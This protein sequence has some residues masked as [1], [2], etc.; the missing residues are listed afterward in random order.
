ME[1]SERIV[2]EKKLNDGISFKEIGRETS[3][4]C[5]TISKE[6]RA[7]RLF[8]QSGAYG[9][10]FNDCL[11]RHGCPQTGLCG[12]P[13]CKKTCC[14]CGLCRPH[15][16]EYKK[17]RCDRHGKPPYVCNGCDQKRKCTLE[18]ALYSATYAQREYAESRSEAHSGIVIGEDEARRLDSVVS[19]LILKGQSVH[20]IL[21]HHGDEIMF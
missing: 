9:R 13:G 1:L 14:F 4:D 3:R 18:K 7:H 20:H 10:F 15:C 2:I 19:P 12:K 11:L 17:E 16:P 8:K 5:T 6:I 21:T